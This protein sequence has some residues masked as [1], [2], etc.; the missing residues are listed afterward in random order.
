MYL[1]VG[2]TTQVSCPTSADAAGI[3]ISQMA[4]LSMIL[5]M[6]SIIVNINNNIN[7]NNNSNNIN[8]DNNLSNNNV[9]LS[10]N[11]NN[12]A[13]V[14]V[15]LPAAGRKKREDALRRIMDNIIEHIKFQ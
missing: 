14:N 12:A 9:Q 8:T 6:F 11:S 13:Q 4:F 1:P 3:S 15:M 7:N 5:T 10:V 2:S